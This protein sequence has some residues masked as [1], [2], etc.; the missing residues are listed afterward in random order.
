MVTR[1]HG[2]GTSD[3][4]SSRPRPRRV[5]MEVGL[6]RRSS[7]PSPPAEG[8]SHVER[9]SPVPRGHGSRSARPGS[10]TGAAGSCQRDPV[11]ALGALE[12]ARFWLPTHKGS[13]AVAVILRSRRAL[14]EARGL[15]FT[16]RLRR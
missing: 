6:L 14:T 3:E 12:A 2:T 15:C 4:V 11:S 5:A 8:G 13:R 10:T 9:S 1:S 16:P 7:G